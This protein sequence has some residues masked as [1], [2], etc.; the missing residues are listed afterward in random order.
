MYDD[1]FWEFVEVA[2]KLLAI[3]A[4]IGAGSL[5]YVVWRLLT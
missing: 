1:D 3:L 4:V 2:F 5:V